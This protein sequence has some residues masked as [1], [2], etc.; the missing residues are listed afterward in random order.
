M[1][2]SLVRYIKII[3]SDK[4]ISDYFF[5]RK[6]EYFANTKKIPENSKKRNASLRVCPLEKHE[7]SISLIK[8]LIQFLFC[9]LF[10]YPVSLVMLNF[11]FRK[12]C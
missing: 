2:K 4:M 9:I 10:I 6:T 5:V 12:L 7:I 3:L 8:V 1:I 11:P